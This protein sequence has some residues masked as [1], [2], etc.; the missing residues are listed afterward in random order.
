MQYTPGAYWP[1]CPCVVS[2]ARLI[3]PFANVNVHAKP[4][5]P[6]PFHVPIDTSSAC[7]SDSGLPRGPVIV[8]SIPAPTWSEP[9]MYANG[10][11]S[12]DTC[13]VSPVISR[14]GTPLVITEP[15]SM[16]ELPAFLRLLVTGGAAT[17]FTV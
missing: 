13:P 16:T 14:F 7:S 9:L 2:V 3:A 1:M 17:M 12:V 5:L 4:V 6:V 10:A 8:P 15:D 11:D